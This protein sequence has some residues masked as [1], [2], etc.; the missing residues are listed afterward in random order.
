[1]FVVCCVVVDEY[2]DKNGLTVPIYYAST[3]AKRCMKVYQTFINMM[4]EKIRA[5]YKVRNPFEFKHISS[6]KSADHF[7]DTGPSVVMAS[8][9]MLQVCHQQHALASFCEQLL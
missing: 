2:W 9:G 7:T 4:N 6:L 5:Q 8:P 1:V 3:L